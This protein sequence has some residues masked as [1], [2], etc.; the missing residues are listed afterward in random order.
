VSSQALALGEAGRAAEAPSTKALLVLEYSGASLL[1]PTATIVSLTGKRLP[2]PVRVRRS[3]FGLSP[4]ARMVAAFTD[5]RSADGVQVGRV[6]RG[7]MK[8]VLRGGCHPACWSFPAASYAWSPDSRRIAVAAE[9]RR[10]S[11]L[12][13][14]ADRDGRVLSSF[15]LPAGLHPRVMSWSPDGSRLLLLQTSEAYEQSVVVLD[16][17]SRRLKTLE[18]LIGPSGAPQLAW[19]PDG[20]FVALTSAGRHDADDLLAVVDASTGRQL[21]RLTAGKGELAA[22]ADAPVWAPDSRSLFVAVY[23]DPGSAQSRTRIDRLYLTG[24]QTQVIRSSSGRLVPRVVTTTGLVYSASRDAG[25]TALNR[26]D[27]GSGR[28]SALMSSRMGI[29]AIF[30]LLR[31]P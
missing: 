25:G 2:V 16:V 27:L 18:R 4:D 28:S 20:R 22:A 30:P 24:R 29:Q 9:T 8:T 1:T 23:D 15:T 13:K 14:L 10:A 26:Y 12:L 17:R 19:S 11:A 31:L 7:A 21:V 5:G 6:R 3:P